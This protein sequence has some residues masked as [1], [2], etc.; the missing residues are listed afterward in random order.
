MSTLAIYR[1]RRVDV[2]DRHGYPNGQRTWGSWGLLERQDWMKPGASMEDRLKFWVELNDYAVS[3]RGESARSE[4]KLE[5]V[6]P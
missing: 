3:Q 4:Y 6:Q 2:R 1:R 5:E